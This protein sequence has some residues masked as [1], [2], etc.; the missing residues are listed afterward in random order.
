M[1]GFIAVGEQGQGSR[2]RAGWLPCA[3]VGGSTALV[4]GALVW[5]R[6]L[7]Y[8]EYAWPVLLFPVLAGAFYGG[9]CGGL[10]VLGVGVAAEWLWFPGTVAPGL[11]PWV[12]VLVAAGLPLAWLGR[13]MRRL[14][15]EN[16]AALA[17][18]R[19]LEQ[20]VA[21]CGRAEAELLAGQELERERHAAEIEAGRRQCR[22]LSERA[23]TA[24]RA[25]RDRE[26]ECRR[27]AG[28]LEELA[29][30]ERDGAARARHAERLYRAVGEALPY[31]VWTADAAGQFIFASESFLDLT[32]LDGGRWAGLG[33]LDAVHPEERERVAESWARAVAAGRSWESEH[34]CQGVDGAWHPLWARGVP[35]RDE[36]G[37][38][39]GW[40]G[41]HLDPGPLRGAEA[42]LRE[43]ELNME[44]C[45]AALAHELRNPLAPILTSAQ[46]LRRRGL[47]RP[48]LL[49]SA[50]ASI[51]RQ[52]KYLARLIG[53]LSDLSRL[54]RGKLEARPKILALDAL[55]AEAVA[56]CQALAAKHGQDW[57]VE[58]PRE[59]VYVRADPERLAQAL[60]HLLDNAVK[61][62]PARGKIRV[63]LAREGEQAVFS[64]RDE[65]V[66]ID[67]GEL[68]RI[69]QPFTQIE[70]SLRGGGHNGLGIGLAL[71]KGLVELQ[72]GS[73]AVHSPG[74]G[75]GSEF[76]VRLPLPE[77]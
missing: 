29:G 72:G 7:G 75:L 33:W 13:G 24:E 66:G 53:D 12:L 47:E 68:A 71:A 55:V 64:L 44:T 25:L 11:W 43:A 38:V 27:L 73:L 8:A 69:F 57:E 3:V 49:E 30:R 59:P 23:E 15:R 45:L 37:G 42:A 1:R 62:T 54:G 46:L 58:L 17:G 63:G 50:T 28:A 20:E 16:R 6:S 18:Q 77:E 39:V 51:E 4:V 40:A 2:A 48:E 26:A 41:V 70:R 67:P 32:G 60:G 34:R 9:F 21:R 56:A 35:V 10:C 5:A 76:V 31:G 52:V 61:F 22:L 14:H 65:G 74:K 36:Q 19:M